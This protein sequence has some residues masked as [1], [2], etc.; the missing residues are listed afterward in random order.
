MRDLIAR[1]LAEHRVISWGN[2]WCKAC[3][4]TGEWHVADE[5]VAAIE[6]SQPDHLIQFGVTQWA[7]QHSMACRLSGRLF[8]C[9]FTA[10][11]VRTALFDVPPGR[12][13][14][15]IDDDGRLVIGQAMTSDA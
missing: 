10:A 2:D 11:A 5:I 9:P 14:C 13:R 7:I 6:A 4:S 12:Y 1:V 3:G 15:T 8:D